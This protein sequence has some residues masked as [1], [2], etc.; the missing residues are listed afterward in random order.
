[1]K[2]SDFDYILP[3]RL[4]AQFPSGKRD[5]CRLL[6]LNRTGQGISHGRFNDLPSILR[7]GDHLVF[8]DTKV[9]PAR[10]LCR[11][12]TG[13][14]I[15][16]LFLHKINDRTW[17]TLVKPAKRVKMGMKLLSGSPPTP[18]FYMDEPNGDG[19]WSVSLIDD[20]ENETIENVLY[21]LGTVPLPNY[22]KR[23][24]AHSDR[25]TYQTVFA[26]NP[27]A[28]AAPTAGLHFSDD[29]IL[30]LREAHI[31]MSF[32]TLHVGIGTFR[33]V[34]ESD[35]RDHTMHK[36]RYS[37]PEETARGLKRTKDTGGRV[38]AVGTTV[39]RVLEHC[40]Q[41]SGL[42][43]ASS[44]ETDMFILPGFSFRAI[45]GMITNFHVPKSTLLM[46]VCAFAGKEFVLDAYR[47]AIE[48]E[49]RFFSYGDAMLLL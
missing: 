8:N 6:L 37:L 1:M 18:M 38:I 25:R 13:G 33:P 35:P 19:A 39:V 44:G 41:I 48:H 45:D 12:E 31:D 14:A 43:V 16:L 34:H 27:G 15:E 3:Q 46:L 2:T 21:R 49:Y 9:L 47:R 11:K 42:T 10:L 22:I 40:A 26:K 36:E 32:V 28:I 24:P 29:L 5:D 17:K 20:R 7:Q 30:R 23:E 4:V